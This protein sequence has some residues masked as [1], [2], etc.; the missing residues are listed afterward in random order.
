MS[1]NFPDT[2]LQ[3][4]FSVNCEHLLKDMMWTKFK[5]IFQLLQK[6]FKATQLT[7][8]VSTNTSK[9]SNDSEIQ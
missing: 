1:T 9:V 3:L 8:T 4:K 6:S 7:H 5:V 2:A